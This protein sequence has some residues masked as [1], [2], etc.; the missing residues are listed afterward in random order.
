MSPFLKPPPVPEG[1][2]STREEFHRLTGLANHSIEW[3]D[4]N[5]PHLAHA[6]SFVPAEPDED[7]MGHVMRQR[8]AR[9]GERVAFLV[10]GGFL[11]GEAL[12][13]ARAWIESSE[14]MKRTEGER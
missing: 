8:R 12:A 3:W 7:V 5:A 4:K 9:Q 1:T 2:I 10:D 14:R 13:N 6:G 11:S